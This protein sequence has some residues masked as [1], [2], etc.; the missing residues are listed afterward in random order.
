MKRFVQTLLIAAGASLAPRRDTVK[1]R[2]SLSCGAGCHADLQ[3]QVIA[4][5]RRSMVR[6][7]FDCWPAA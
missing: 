5:N 1:Q 2:G 7:P 6:T 4:D 3:C